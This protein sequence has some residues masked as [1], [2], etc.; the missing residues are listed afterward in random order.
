MGW[1]NGQQEHTVPYN[2]TL[3]EIQVYDTFV[4][5]PLESVHINLVPAQVLYQNI[6]CDLD[7]SSSCLYYPE[8]V[9][10]MKKIK[11]LLECNVSLIDNL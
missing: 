1:L 11:Y 5:L 10:L 8:G 7:V 2:V 9:R 6:F 4:P 3:V